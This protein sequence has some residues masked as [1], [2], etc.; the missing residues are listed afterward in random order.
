[1]YL[2]LEGG[3]IEYLGTYCVKKPKG[4]KLRTEEVDVPILMEF[5]TLSPHTWVV[6]FY[7]G[8]Y[9][10]SVGN[11]I[12]M[13]HSYEEDFKNVVTTIQEVSWLC[14]FLSFPSVSFP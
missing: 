6:N 12:R 1:M 14:D 4:K 13:A 10:R 2:I 9:I 3:C 8:C 5:P 7:A 11:S